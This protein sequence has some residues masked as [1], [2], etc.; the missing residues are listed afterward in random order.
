M[1]FLCCFCG[2]TV[3]GAEIGSDRYRIPP[4][5]SAPE[6]ENWPFEPG[7]T[8]RCSPKTFQDGSAGL[9]AIARLRGDGGN[10]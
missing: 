10:A 6:G 2:S 5:A 8:V 7:A 4:S 1:R 3:E 9:V